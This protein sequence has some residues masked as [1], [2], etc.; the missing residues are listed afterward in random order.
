MLVLL[1]CVAI[2]AWLN[3]PGLRWLA[4]KIANQY[5]TKAGYK[6][7]FEVEGNLTGGLVL[8]NLHLQSDRAIASVRIDELIPTYRLK[9]LSKGRLD[10]LKI[11]GLHIDLRLGLENDRPKERK[12]LDQARL[13]SALRSIRNRVIP[14]AAEIEDITLRATK[15]GKE[16][17][18]LAESSIRH[19]AG[20][21]LIQIDIGAITDATGRHWPAQ[22]TSMVWHEDELTI[23]RIDPLRRMSLRQL[24]LRTE[25]K[26]YLSAE[27]ELHVDE[28]VFVVSAAPGLSPI[29]INLR[30][31]RLGSE[32][33]AARLAMKLPVS[34]ELSSFTAHVDNLLTNPKASVGSVQLLLEK[35]SYHDREIPQLSL[36]IGLEPGQATL[37][38]HANALGDVTLDAVADV[39]RNEGEFLLGRAHGHFKVADITDLIAELAERH[40]AINQEVFVPAGTAEGDLRLSFQHNRVA[41]AEVIS[42]VAPSDPAASSPISLKANWQPRGPLLVKLSVDG[43]NGD[44]RYDFAQK[45]YQGSIIFDGFKTARVDPWLTVFKARFQGAGE[46][47]GNWNGEG[48]IKDNLHR[49]KLEVTSAQFMRDGMPPVHGRGNVHYDWPTRFITDGMILTSDNQS[50]ALDLKLAD[51]ILEMPHLRWREGDREM[52]SGSASLPVPKGFSTWRETLAQDSRPIA[53]SVRSSVLPLASLKNWFPLAENLDHRSTGMLSVQMSG[54]YAKPVIAAMLEAKEL[55]SPQKPRLPPAGLKMTLDARDNRILMD[56]RISTAD[57]PPAVITASMPFRPA[58]WMER[59][60][61]VMTEPVT[62]R[63][64]LPRIDLSR[65][66]TLVPGVKK[67]AGLLAGNVDVAGEVGK[68]V[69]KG[70]LVLTSGNIEMKR[71]DISPITGISASVDLAMHQITLSKLQATVAG[72]TLR[73]AGSLNIENGKP[74]NI[75]LTAKGA[76]I[77]LR[78][79]NALIVRANADL[80]LSGPWQSA[81]LT[82][83]LGVV[84]SMYF[85]DIEILPIGRPFTGP[86]AAKLPKLARPSKPGGTMPEPFRNWKLDVFARTDNPFLIRG[87]V[88]TGS[89]V[90][91]VRI[92]G[93]LGSPEPTG[94]VRVSNVRASLPF[95]T[96][97]VRSGTLRFTPE[98]KFDPILELRGIAEPR[99]Y[100]VYVYVHGQASDPQLILTSSPPLPE[101]EI[102]TLLATGTTTAGLEDPQAASSRA[103]QLFAE[104]LRRGRFGIGKR[105]R[106]LLKLLDRVDF[107]LAEKD[108][109]SSESYSSAT[110]QV[111]DRWY[112]TASMGAEGDTRVLAIWRLRFK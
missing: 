54:S 7:T 39:N 89:A 4:P 87:N 26:G 107:T 51:G 62:A 37:A 64:D 100:Q 46:L 31:G 9:Q 98:T 95:S 85:R 40:P 57:Y 58:E 41:S 1:G 50:V 84:D 78:R 19:R 77:P 20:E 3:G 75:D 32:A 11:D 55:R 67:L 61:L 8:K 88:A 74:G 63:A 73:A 97:T 96:L 71:A 28:A 15:D 35:V 76:H 111:T 30:E 33:V 24:V 83:S 49:G 48:S 99:P 44:A 6:G 53:V 14:L 47:T 27:T 22:A 5:L 2:V 82:G 106:P 109:Y 79:D 52:L 42:Q 72:G 104:E 90:G 112:L 108:P 93:S 56:A 45:S 59:P 101:N 81:S 25:D 13:A 91:E 102:M 38:A 43:A 94:E 110:L 105:L 10:G 17:I 69:M 29:Q 103:L 68:P 66:T 65:F 36:D 16:V 80:R 86:S 60:G 34:A 12:P 23:D 18:A 21:P 70:R 92:R